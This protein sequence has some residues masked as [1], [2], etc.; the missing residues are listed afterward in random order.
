[1][2][3]KVILENIKKHCKSAKFPR[4]ID[5]RIERNTLYITLHFK[6]LV[7]N[8]QT[9]CAAFEGWAMVIKH[10]IGADH[11]VLN[12]ET[13]DFSQI[14]EVTD[15]QRNG[16]QV[17]RQDRLIAQQHYTRFQYRVLKFSE[18]Y[19]WF[20]FSGTMDF[21]YSNIV[22]NY[23]MSGASKDAKTEEAILERR[24]VEKHKVDYGG[25]MDH[26]F[27]LTMFRGSISSHNQITS[28]STLD[29][30]AIDDSKVEIF[31]LKKIKGN[32]KVGI[33]TEILY[34]VNVM[35][36]LMKHKVNYPSDA[37]GCNLRS[38]GLI[39]SLY[40]SN[41]AKGVCGHLLCDNKHP[42]IDSGVLSI[43]SSNRNGLSFDYVKLDL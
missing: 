7:S 26:Q 43:M 35:D 10:H 9:D 31:E 36:D 15:R 25:K 29:I 4:D 22:L 17:N 16:K 42:L 24:F 34:Y 3:K 1:M 21:D 38:F 20:S 11:V 40:K 30:W 6:G 33:I 27:P 32:D 2:D 28:K 13:P 12:W 39:H 14:P 19:D 37:A 41:R 23:P 8:M 18:L 5:F